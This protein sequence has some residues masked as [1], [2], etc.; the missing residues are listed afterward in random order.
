MAVVSGMSSASEVPKDMDE[1]ILKT[2]WR[3]IGHELL[4]RS[5]DS[6]SRV[7]PI[8]M[9][10]D[11]L[12]MRFESELKLDPGDL[13]SLV[14]ASLKELPQIRSYLV[15][16]ETCSSN[17]LAYSYR[18]HATDRP[19]EPACRGRMLPKGCYRILFTVL[20]A[21]GIK[22]TN[23]GKSGTWSWMLSISAV[24]AFA[25]IGWLFRKRNRKQGEP[26]PVSTGITMGS[27]QFDPQQMKLIRDG[28]T[29]ELTGKET[30]LLQQLYQCVNEVV[31][32]EA[33]LK[34]VW[35]DEGD[36][37]GRTL[38]VFISRLRKKLEADPSI[39]ILNIRGVGYKL[40]IG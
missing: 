4:L 15:E 34:Q 11:R 17:A 7:L 16:V 3:K 12:I 40:V 25:G 22:A 28:E 38:D 9:E 24:S 32:K 31:E 13:T 20:N 39:R 14:N 27:F 30:E 6:T 29:H 33:L 1:R 35:G 2:V 21:T 23:P 10:K 5:G 8:E 19:E 37:I 18:V 36:Y 26:K